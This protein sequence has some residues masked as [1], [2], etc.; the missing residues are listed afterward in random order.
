M[1]RHRLKRLLTK[2]LA[3]ATGMRLFHGLRVWGGTYTERMKL[4][5]PRLA[6]SRAA[7][8]ALCALLVPPVA[9]SQSLQAQVI[10]K[11]KPDASTVRQHALSARAEGAAVRSALTGRAGALGQRVGRALEAGAAV[12]ERV[13]VVRASGISSAELAAQLAADPDVEFAEP[14]VRARRLA[15]GSDE[16]LFTTGPTLST[17]N[18]TGGPE[19]GQWYLRAPETTFAALTGSSGPL[20]VRSAINAEAAWQRTAGVPSVVIAI[21]DTGIRRNHPEFVAQTYQ[22][23]DFVD[24]STFSADGDGRD[25]D[26]TDPGD[27]VSSAEAA[28]AAFRDADCVVESSSWHGT[29]T[30]SLAAAPANGAG[31]S[32]VAPGA[33]LLHV[34][35]LGKCG[36]T[37][38]DI[39][40]AM[41]WAV[42]LEVPG[43]PLNQNPA[44]VLNLSLGSPRATCSNLYQETV[45]AVL[46]TGASI[47]VSAGNGSGDAVSQPANCAGVIAVAALRHSGTKSLFSNLGPEVAIAAPGANCV[48]ISA[49][50]A[51]IF[52]L[53]AA[54]NLGAT[55]PANDSWFDSY[56]YE[57][58]TSFSA[59]LVAGVAAL[60]YS[61]NPNLTAAQVRSLL[62][63]TARPFPADSS[64]PVCRA[65]DGIAQDECQCTSTTCGAGM[66]DAAA[67]VAA[68]TGVPAVARITFTPGTPT[69]GTTV[70]LSAADST[71]TGGT[72][73]TGYQWAL[74]DGGNPPIVS[75]FSSA[76]NAVTASL[77][78][79]ASGSFTVTLAVTDGLANT[80]LAS[81]TVTVAGTP[82]TIT[83][84]SPGM[85]TLGTAPPALAATASS[86]LLVSISSGTTAVCTVSG[87]TLTLVA[88]GT[89]TLTATQAGDAAYAAAPAVSQTFTVAA[90]VTVNGGGGGGGGAL[91]VPWLALLALA[92]LAL[93]RAPRRA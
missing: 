60:M 76:N 35:V 51:C 2:R 31:M 38:A 58:G 93:F 63:S 4:A 45:N 61:V 21:L 74:S 43:V 81:Q 24:D 75:G 85:Q 78:P 49:G 36:G 77:T 48:N 9:A 73:I 71:P 17:R 14:N 25:A 52:P 18:R 7:G 10:V 86:G 46:A 83:F 12:S 72:V 11:F 28:T 55:G 40:A 27:F 20:T 90:V 62:R 22:G 42:G 65:P 37:A 39:Q 5:I 44:K 70:T 80:A 54:T 91:S 53:L 33:R 67:A 56:R 88:A 26:A 16:P 79:T 66:L 15:G 34:R 82:Q 1:C 50:A 89:C 47:V 8:L 13:Q 84:N 3:W 41:R 69:A 30:A 57:I 92:V 19:S 6:R 87:S 64:L 29:A 68:V 23:Y 59:P 32:G